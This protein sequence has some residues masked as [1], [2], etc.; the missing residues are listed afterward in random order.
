MNPLLR[1]MVDRNASDLH[2][3]AGAPPCLR[4]DE[5]LLPV[6]GGTMTPEDSQRLAYSLL[7]PAQIERFERNKELDMSF[8]ISG[9]GRFRVN[10]FYQRGSVGLA[11]RLLPL[12]SRNFAQCGLP[13][14]IATDLCRR[15]RGLVLVTGATGSGKSTTLAA[16][17]EWIN[18]ERQCHI[19]T[20]EDP[21]EYI[22]AN[23][24]AII[25]QREIGTDTHSFASA[26]KYS[27]RQDPNVILIGEM[28]DL[29][30]I[31][32][33]LTIA[34]TGHLVFAT[35]HTSD[36]VQTINRVVDVFPAHQ[37]QQVRI[38]L[39]FVLLGAMAQQLI[40][41]IGG[42][43]TLAV[44]VMLATPAVRSLIREGKTHQVYSVIQT[45]QREG[46]RTM[47]Q[48][49]A[50]LYLQKQ[51]SHEDAVGRSTDPDELVRLIQ[52]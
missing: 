8:G 17:V 20:I 5:K 2:I 37:Q 7:T 27:L 18:Q 14:K 44:E 33:A 34:E 12:A 19:V 50:D 29:E 38:Q 4:V 49:L 41:K 46:M 42:G 30:T 45:S 48:S 9:L 13:E 25:D 35:L 40:P 15:P 26:L 51:I 43:R 16:M 24:K 23:A 3:S 1:Q 47:N 11:I 6:E 32:A 31:E 39:S 52:R 22:H 21:V 28:R 36:A 10:V